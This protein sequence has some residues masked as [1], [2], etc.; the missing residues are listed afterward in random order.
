VTFADGTE[1]EVVIGTSAHIQQATID[2]ICEIVDAA[3][4]GV[5]KHKRVDQY[6]A[7]DRLE[8]GDAGPQANRVLHLA[9]KGQ[10]LVGCASSTFSPGWTPDGCGHWGLLAVDPAHQ[11]SG[12]AT[13]LVVAAERRLATV[14]AGVQIEYQY[15]EGEEFSQ[16]LRDWYEGKLKFQ[17]GRHDLQPG[18]TIFRRCRKSIPAIEQQRGHF[19]RLQ[20][21]EKWLK[22]QLEEV[23]MAEQ[24]KSEEEAKIQTSGQAASKGYPVST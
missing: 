4:S 3:Y 10:E 16:R 14:C 21:I 6:D 9:Y 2:R 11:K 17:G 8:M 18:Q 7:V 19:R 15:T 12:V 20:E 23:T 24:A 1:I 13:A 22:L 5:G